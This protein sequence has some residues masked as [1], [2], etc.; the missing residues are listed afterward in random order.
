MM[1]KLLAL[2]APAALLAAVV[3]SDA[4]AEIPVRPV[5]PPIRFFATT[6][7]GSF[8]VP[9]NPGLPNFG[10][11]NI[12]VTATSKD[13]Y[14]PPGALFATPKWTRHVVASGNYAAGSC[15]YSMAVPGNSAFYLD[16]SGG[17]SYACDVIETWVGPSGAAVGPYS[18]AF[19]GSA[20]ENF[21]ITRVQCIVI[22]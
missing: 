15:S 17:G 2:A 13:T 16:A 3:A 5:M 22:K 8:T 12:T 1:K 9:A 18:V 14:T 4:N 11:G 19:G 20:T 6:V 21:A 10:C 7:Q